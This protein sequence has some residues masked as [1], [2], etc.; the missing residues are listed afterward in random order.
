[1][2]YATVGQ[3]LGHMNVGSHGSG[4]GQGLDHRPMR[5]AA[6]F[7]AAIVFLLESTGSMS[8]QS[9][10]DYLGLIDRYVENADAAIKTLASWPRP[11]ILEG[12]DTCAT[13][14]NQQARAAA[15]MLHS[16]VAAPIVDSAP[17]EATS[18]IRMA[19]RLLSRVQDR[20][21][22]VQR[23]YEFTAM[24]YLSNGHFQDA[25]AVAN[26]GLARY[27]RAATLYAARGAV[28]G[29]RVAL[30]DRR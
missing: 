5:C 2:P 26:E 25:A 28:A 1:M 24:L 29:N 30:A 7:A 21:V 11:A 16:D 20:P 23:W 6:F 27:P 8:A 22:F 15:A 17:D 9:P 10:G 18:H 12:V 4:E 14:C 19:G 3:R 13:M